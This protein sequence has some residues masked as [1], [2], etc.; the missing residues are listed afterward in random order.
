MNESVF[1]RVPAFST[2]T[3]AHNKFLVDEKLAYIE[4]GICG[5]KLNPMWVIG[6][7][8]NRE[9]RANRAV[10]ALAK[11]VE[12][13]EKKNSCKCEKCGQMTRIVK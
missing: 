4:C 5:E 1:K 12:E 10:E 13:A 11:V 7:L 2:K 3:C 8:C 6:Q 9:A